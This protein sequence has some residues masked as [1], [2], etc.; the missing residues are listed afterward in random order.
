MRT[1]KHLAACALRDE[2]SEDPREKRRECRKVGADMKARRRVSAGA[3]VGMG[4]GG[5]GART[6]VFT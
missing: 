6:V 2:L 4:G 5:D 1:E 3:R